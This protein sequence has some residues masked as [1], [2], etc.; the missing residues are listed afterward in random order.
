MSKRNFIL[1]IIVLVIIILM[2]FGFLYFQSKTP[3]GEEGTGTNF[4]SQFNPFGNG[5]KKNGDD[6]G[7]PPVDVS[8]YEPPTQNEEL[9]L[10][11]V[12]SM[13][14]AGFSVFQKERLKEVNPT[15]A[16]PLSGEGESV[17]PAKGDSGGQKPTPPA[18]E[19]APALRYVD[20]ATGNVYQTF[21]DKI[22][23][24]KFSGTTI[25]KVYEAFFGNKGDAV[26]MRYLKADGK[27]IQTFWGVLPKEVLGGDSAGEMEIR[28]TFLPDNITDI[29]LSPDT[30]SIFY[31]F[32]AGEGAIGTTLDLVAG[33]KVQVFDSA[34][35]EWLSFWPNSK[36]I[37]LTTKPSFL[38]PGYMYKVDPLT[39][40]LT[41]VLGKINGLTTLASPDGKLVLYS[42]NAL[43]LRIYHTDT[44]ETDLLGVKTLPE[45]C[46]WVKGSDFIYCSVPKAVISTSYPDTW[47]QGEVSFGDQIWKINVVS[48]NVEMIADLSAMEGGPASPSQGGEEIDGIKLSLDE[49]ENYLFFV[50]KKDS[51]LWKLKIK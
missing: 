25:P 48:G 35:T 40:S 1:L 14:V 23:E 45:K 41:Q 19:F 2:F 8:G 30:K 16:L 20:R 37:T 27:I 12:S 3:A 31:L 22:E 9:E 10:T 13:P 26:I 50:N 36:M 18:T 43:A 39:K 15:P 46:V 17:P 38:V 24:R 51:F 28:G 29:S 34:F 32:N 49:G 5:G 6:T 11:K 47:Y 21:A 42:D 7:T 33:K 44:K 4:I